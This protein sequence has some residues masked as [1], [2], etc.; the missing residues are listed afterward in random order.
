MEAGTVSPKG[1]TR[2]DEENLL[3]FCK[4]VSNVIDSVHKTNATRN[5]IR[6]NVKILEQQVAEVRAKMVG[7]YSELFE[8]SVDSARSVLKADRCSLWLIDKAKGELWSK[9]A[10]GTKPLRMRVGFVVY[11]AGLL[12]F[13]GWVRKAAMFSIAMFSIR[14]NL[15]LCSSCHSMAHVA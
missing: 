15:F 9:I 10:Q 13:V 12:S 5:E 3:D 1:F 11:L 2:A 14:R 4:V 6:D 8:S 7:N